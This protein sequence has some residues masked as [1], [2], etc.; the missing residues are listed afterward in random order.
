MGR[1]KHIVINGFSARRGGGQTYLVNLCKHHTAREDLKITLLLYKD[2][3]LIIKNPSIRVVKIRF[4]VEN[5]FMRFY[6]ETFRLPQLL[7]KESA[8]LLFCPGGIISTKNPNNC[9]KV[10]MFRNMVPLDKK[11]RKAYPFGYMRFRNWLLKYSLL[12]SMENADLVIFISE[13]GKEVVEGISK[14]GIMK[15]IVIPHGVD[16]FNEGKLPDKRPQFLPKEP[17]IVYVSTV[18]VYKSQ[19]EVVQAY[20]L[21]TMKGVALPKL[22]LVGPWET[23]GYVKKIE[24]EIH[25]NG[26]SKKIFLTGPVL[27]EQMSYVYK[28]AQFVIF[29]SQSENCPNILLESMA[30]GRAIMC[31]NRPPMPEFA[32]DA[33]LY[34]DP[35]D[36]QNIANTMLRLLKDESQIIELQTKALERSRIYN[37]ESSAKKTWDVL[38]NETVS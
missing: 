12:R 37:W 30:S 29:A 10:T 16:T 8:D 14:K 17:Y 11:Q 18:D 15:S 23:L 20:K 19:L 38:I 22:L 28:D 2:S 3:D 34:F 4:P 31:S 7:V 21:L 36:P 13:F 25:G 32:G 26:L 33:V 35:E 9:K 5:P 1:C 6:W 27:Y 24:K